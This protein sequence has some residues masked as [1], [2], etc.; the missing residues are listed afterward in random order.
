MENGAH[1]SG[2]Y[3][4]FKSCNYTVF[5]DVDPLGSL[6]GSKT[7]T[8]PVRGNELQHRI[9]TLCKNVPA[10]AFFDQ[11]SHCWDH[12]PTR[13]VFVVAHWA[14][15]CMTCFKHATAHVGRTEN[16]RNN[17]WLNPHLHLVRRQLHNYLWRL[18]F[19]FNN[20]ICRR[21]QRGVCTEAIKMQHRRPV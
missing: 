13:P 3:D 20:N 9:K 14:T 5:Y 8:L 1:Y 15:L 18:Q 21:P 4:P 10:T 7:A 12:F 17:L 2:I 6:L 11:K 19:S 16:G